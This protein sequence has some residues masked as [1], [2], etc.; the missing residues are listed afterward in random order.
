MRQV[1]REKRKD[2]CKAQHA[3]KTWLQEE[4]QERMALLQAA[5]MAILGRLAMVTTDKPPAPSA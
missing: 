4:S 1:K 3:I 2:A 5:M